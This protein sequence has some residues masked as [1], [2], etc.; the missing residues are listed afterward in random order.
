M[1]KAVCPMI[2]RSDWGVGQVNQKGLPHAFSLFQSPIGFHGPRTAGWFVFLNGTHRGED[3]RIPVGETKVGSH[4]NSDFV[5]TGVGIGGHHATL[6]AGLETIS[7]EPAAD[8]RETKVN[9]QP[10]KTVTTLT[11]GCLVSLGDLHAIFR[12]AIQL[13]RPVA[14]PP[15]QKPPSLPLQGAP[16]V[17]VCGWLICQKGTLMGR[18]FRLR[19]G[20]SRVGNAKN[21]EISLNDGTSADTTFGLDC[22]PNKIIKIINIAPGRVVKVNDKVI[23]SGHAVQDSD[24]IQFD[25]MELLVKCF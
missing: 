2:A 1:S 21:I 6:R 16:K 9:N 12:S 4:W 17:F 13:P 8:S 18:D 3:M 7:I 20:L 24:M 5:L 22:Q 15:Y 23:D 14:I 19:N 25:R 10:I 11:D